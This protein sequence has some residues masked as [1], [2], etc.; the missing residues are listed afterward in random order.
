MEEKERGILSYR[1]SSFFPFAKKEREREREKK[2]GW[3]QF[4]IRER[5]EKGHMRKVSKI[6]YR[7]SSTWCVR[8]LEGRRALSNS[9][10]LKI[11]WSVGV[12]GG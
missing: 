10:E 11:L 3:E 4:N 12:K 7:R 9:L 5:K 8:T 1:E 6:E 2:E